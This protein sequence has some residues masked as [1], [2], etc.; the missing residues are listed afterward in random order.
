[1][2]L[3]YFNS[4]IGSCMI[5]ILIAVDYL[6]RNNTDKFQRKLFL[7]MLISVFIAAAADYIG[8]VLEGKSG[9]LVNTVLYINWSLYYVFRNCCY[10][11]GAVFIDYFTHGDIARAKSFF[12]K[13]SIF[14]FFYIISI[15]FN[16]SGEYFFYITRENISIPGS[17]FILHIAISYIPVTIILIDISLAPKRVKKEQI[18]VIVFFMIL[19]AIGAVFDIILRKT[20][21]VWSC[22]TAG[23]LYC[24][25]FIIRSNSG[26]NGFTGKFTG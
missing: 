24:Y 13:V 20:S 19:I 26:E 21:L 14:L 23:A 6:R 15:I 18:L 22:I 2:N 9:E 5:I 10:Y 7:L 8:M 1:M 12:T 25:F 11:Y 4:N 3:N 17:F 16:Y